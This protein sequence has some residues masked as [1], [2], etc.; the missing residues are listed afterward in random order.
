MSI[1]DHKMSISVNIFNL[2][3]CASVYILFQ[4]CSKYD[5][6]LTRKQPPHVVLDTT[7]AGVGS[8]TVKSFTVAL[9]IPTVTATLGQEGDLRQWR[10][11]NDAKKNYLLQVGP[12]AHGSFTYFPY[13]IFLQIMPPADMIPQVIRSII[14]YMNITNAAI[15]YD[16]TFVMDHKYKSLLQNTANRNVITAIAKNR[17]IKDQLDKLRNLDIVNFF[18]LG[19]L[20]SIKGVLG[21]TYNYHVS[22][23]QSLFQRL[24]VKNI[25]KEILP[26]TQSPNIMEI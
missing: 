6:M 25:S 9:G 13:V 21:K 7:L 26:G 8:E 11:L 18:I 10:N 24:H 22:G 19:S 15:L 17:D 12:C 20:T 3:I 23:L 16:D 5:E 2:Y 1:V 14:V 4:V